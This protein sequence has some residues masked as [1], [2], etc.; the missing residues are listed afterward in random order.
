MPTPTSNRPTPGRGRVWASS[1]VVVGLLAAALYAVERR[2]HEA[3]LA[4][5]RADVAGRL[6]SYERALSNAVFRRVSI[7]YGARSWLRFD[8]D[9]WQDSFESFAGDLA[10]GVDGIRAIQVVQGG[11]IR[12]TWPLEGNEAALGLD[13]TEHP[14]PRI[15]ADLWRAHDTGAL[16]VSD[17]VELVQG[18]MGVI[19]RL[20]SGAPGDREAPSAAAILDLAPVLEEAGLA[21]ARAAGL[22][23]FVE[24]GDGRVFAGERVGAEP[25]RIAVALPDGVWTVGAEP[26][27]GW[28]GAVATR[29]ALLLAAGLVVMLLAGLLTFSIVDR[30][31]RLRTAVDRRT[32]E[33]AAAMDT[34]RKQEAFLDLALR[35]G[36]V[37][38][39]SWELGTDRVVRS[40]GVDAFFGLAPEGSVDDVRKLV[41]PDDRDDLIEAHEAAVSTGALSVEYRVVRPDGRVLWIRDEGRLLRTGT[42]PDRLVGAM[43]D[44]TRVKELEQQLLHSQRMEEVGRLA[45]VVAHDFNNLLTVMQANLELAQEE[46]GGKAA[47]DLKQVSQAIE[48]ASFLTRKLLVFSRRDLIRPEIMEF[49]PVVL[50]I[51]DMVRPILGSSARLDVSP[52]A[53]GVRVRM[54]RGQLTQIIFNLAVNARD[55]MSEGG[56]VR[57][58]TALDDA[59]DAA[60]GAVPGVHLIVEDSGTGIPP[61]AL[62]S[63]F[64]PFMTTKGQEQGTGLGLSTVK[65][66]VEGVGGRIWA[67]NV[68]SGGARFVVVVPV[69]LRPAVPV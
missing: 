67:E 69:Q 59:A 21:A 43:A 42:E 34:L 47:D 33:L 1:L 9:G 6:I 8:A 4:A 57:V 44:V 56:T 65:T 22:R 26:L 28:E 5:A 45:A 51:A 17:P 39:W 30:Q 49:D 7:L 18:G 19:V 20:T 63:I 60:L 62:G 58:R 35:A 52:G 25:A 32:A 50:E 10:Q 41:H 46:L 53:E 55:A 66:I 64:E 24:D 68:P 40:G 54:D 2:V 11:V 61:D 15:T 13:L 3:S 14:L 29:H 23:I 36:R 27:D 31:V 12:R 16:V 38:A 37:F 48:H